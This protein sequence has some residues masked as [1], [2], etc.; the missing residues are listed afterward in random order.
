MKML[1]NAHKS[2]IP[3]DYNINESMFTL[4]MK[5]ETFQIQLKSKTQSN[6]SRAKIHYPASNGYVNKEMKESFNDHNLEHYIKDY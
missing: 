2:R 6:Q 1:N 3:R 5:E 4:G